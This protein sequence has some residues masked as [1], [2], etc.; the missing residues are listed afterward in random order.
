MRRII[1]KTFFFLI[2]F[3]AVERFC[4]KYTHGFRLQKIHSNLL[5]NADWDT[6][7][8]SEEAMEN[9][10]SLLSQS[11]F[12]LGS[13]GECY[14]FVSEDGKT[15]L[16]LFKHHHMRSKSWI[17]VLPLPQFLEPLRTK[18]LNIRLRRLKDIFGSC[19]IAYEHFQKETGLIYLHLNKTNELHLKLKLFDPI[20][21]V[22]YIDLDNIEFALQK[23]ASMAYPTLSALIKAEELEA[24]KLRLNALLDLI[25]ARCRAGIAD[26]DPRKRNFGFVGPNAIE[27][28]LGSFS[29]NEELKD[30]NSTKKVLLHETIKL[31]RFIK[32]NHP[33][34]SEYLDENIKSRI[35]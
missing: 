7:T 32:K 31:R 28:D 24:A 5:H 14:A 13:G 34:L 23:R 26:H 25:V 4:H 20:R 21:A 33:E 6:T 17:N 19:K 1:Y 18:H 16:K 27:F 9:V 30:P 12:F 35:M 3:I 10:R 29:I 22:H 15:V 2:V 8:P 11:Y